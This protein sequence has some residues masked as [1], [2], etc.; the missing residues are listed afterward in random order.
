MSNHII[1]IEKV[2]K[3]FPVGEG[4]FTA[5]NQIDLQFEKGEFAG[6][7]G[8]SGSGKTTLLN[9][10]GSLDTPTEGNAIVMG[11]NIKNLSHKESA[12][13]RN[14]HLGFI[15]QVFNLLP[16][17]TVFENVEFALI[18]QNRSASER[19][20]AVMEALEWVGLE[21]MAN[22][23]P[24]KLSGGEGQRVAIARAMVKRPDIVLADEPTANLDAKNAHA[25]IQT[26]KKLNEELNTTFLFSTHDEKVMAYMNRM[27][28]LEDGKVVKDEIIEI[29]RSIL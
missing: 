8:P 4:E 14:K 13:L 23:K 9:I 21:N 22:K 17:Y 11:K 15:F 20:K 18:L 28:H 1:S 26:M 2:T 10:I 27:V 16:V 12:G 5:L 29:Q 6:I 3:R 25:I 7:V 19:K 24:A